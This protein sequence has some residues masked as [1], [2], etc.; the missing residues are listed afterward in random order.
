MAA[1]ALDN[2]NRRTML[3][4]FGMALA[5]LGLGFAAVPLYNLFCRVTGF[6][7]TTQV[8]TEAE[9]DLAARMA[10]SAGGKTYSIRFDANT[11][12]DMPWTFE[13][14]QVTDTIT[15]G[16]RDMATYTARNNSSEPITG[17]ATFNVE[18]E[19]AG[20][21]FNKIQCFCFTEQ[22]LQPGQ[23][24]RMPVLYYVDPKA[25]DDPNMEGV[26][27]ITLSYTFHRAITD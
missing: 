11:A 13:P 12:S 27:Q 2:R 15:I 22:T 18:P 1:G 26:E 23:E 16:Q 17:T 25:L 19:Q 6:A 9:A 3:M 24:V 7:G 21:Y 10:Q 4:A 5:M 8:A 14:V 20:I